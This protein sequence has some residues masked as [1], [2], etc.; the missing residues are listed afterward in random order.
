MAPWLHVGSMKKNSGHMEPIELWYG[1]IN[2]MMMEQGLFRDLKA[3]YEKNSPF[4][5]E[6]I[7]NSF[8]PSKC[9]HCIYAPDFHLY[10]KN[11]TQ[12]E[13]KEAFRVIHDELGLNRFIFDGRAFTEQCIRAIEYLKE[14]FGDV[15]VGLITDGISI[16]P[17]V[18]RLIDFPPDWLDVSVDGLEK[19]HDLQRN[20]IG[21]FRKTFDVLIQ[22]KDSNRFDKIN[23]L[24]CLTTLNIGSI[25]EMIRF[26]NAKGFKNFFITPVSVLKG[27]RPDPDLQPQREEFVNFLDEFLITSNTL[28]DTWLEVDIYEA[29]Y[30]NTIR[31]L[32]P[33][34]FNEFMMENDHLELVKAHGNNEVHISYY[35]L[36]LTGVREFIV[37]SDGNIIPPKVVAMGKIPREF[38]FGNLLELGGKEEKFD[39]LMSSQAFSFYMSELLSEKALLGR[40]NGGIPG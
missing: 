13:W 24:S 15:K 19:E 9:Q 34:L 29:I 8:C 35:P 4:I 2:S 17:F 22:L 37:N 10:N 16:G 12:D 31:Q 20:H 23:I 30:A 33:Q 32:R 38:V 1:L 36:S 5:A 7:M 27:Y 3:V 14:N 11:L 25:L 21:A 39:Q 28:F 6:I 40:D 26:L 18:E